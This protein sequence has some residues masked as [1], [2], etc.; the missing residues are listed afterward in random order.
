MPAVTS[1]KR[2]YQGW[3]VVGCAFLIAVF[4]WGFGFYGIGVFL[5]E[6]VA[7]RLGHELRRV[8]GHRPLP[9]GARGQCR[10]ATRP[11]AASST[12]RTFPHSPSGVNGFSM[13]A[14]PGSSTPWWT[15]ASS[16]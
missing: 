5:V 2:M 15:I 1:G 14:V 3:K 10:A 8:G 13:K 9:R 6:L 11:A 4:G 7:P 12:S 16:V